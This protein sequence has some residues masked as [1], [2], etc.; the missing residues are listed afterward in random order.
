MIDKALGLGCPDPAETYSSS[1]HIYEE[2]DIPTDARGT[3][4][5][6]RKPRAKRAPAD[7]S[8]ERPAR[9]R[10]R[11]RRR[12]RGGEASGHPEGTAEQSAPAK[13]DATAEGAETSPS[14][15][16]RRRRRPRKTAASA[17]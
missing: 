4:G 16:R 8:A 9:N 10:T 11:N 7:K 17:G 1:P 15:P 2:L 12:T 3:I 6:A 14:G 13:D 5:E